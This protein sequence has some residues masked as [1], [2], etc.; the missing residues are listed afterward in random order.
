[1]NLSAWRREPI[2]ADFQRCRISM[3]RLPFSGATFED[4][5]VSEEGRQ[6]LLNRLQRV[7]EAD[8]RRIFTAARFPEFH[9]GTDDR[10]D[11]DAWVEAFRYRVRQIE[12]ARCPA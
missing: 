2:W 4:A 6:L 8:L 1:V 12:R 3:S 10:R 9:S 7:T 5:V 11:L